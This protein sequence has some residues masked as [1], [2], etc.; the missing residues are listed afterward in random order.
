MLQKMTISLTGFDIKT[1]G[2][3]TF[4]MSDGSEQTI[5]FGRV[6]IV[7]ENGRTSIVCEEPDNA[8]F[9][10]WRVQDIVSG[11]ENFKTYDS[12]TFTTTKYYVVFTEEMILHLNDKVGGSK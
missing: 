4:I 11:V 5:N 2:A 12:V 8:E 7:A 10:P 3:F 1:K 6:A 9:K